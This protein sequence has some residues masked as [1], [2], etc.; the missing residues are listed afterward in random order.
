M[1]TRHCGFV[2]GV[3]WQSIEESS[4]DLTPITWLFRVSFPKPE[5]GMRTVGIREKNICNCKSY[6]VT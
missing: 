5:M 4:S 3:T 2:E 1:L 6:A